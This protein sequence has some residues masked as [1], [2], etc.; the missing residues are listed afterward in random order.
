MTR[1][2]RAAL[3]WLGATLIRAQGEAVFGHVARKLD[4]LSA[5]PTASASARCSSAGIA[6][7]AH[8][9]HLGAARLERA[10]LVAVPG[11]H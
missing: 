7:V 4:V 9:L 8:R 2:I 10:D 3:H 11:F 6:S 1:P 5:G